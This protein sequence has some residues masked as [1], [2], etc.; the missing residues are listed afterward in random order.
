MQFR[1][2]AQLLLRASLC[3]SPVTQN[4]PC[5]VGW[6]K[7]PARG[8]RRS[9]PVLC[10]ETLR[11]P[12]GQGRSERSPSRTDG[13][14][15]LHSAVPRSSRVENKHT[16]W[17]LRRAT[18]R[19]WYSSAKPTRE[20]DR[21]IRKWFHTVLFIVSPQG[22]H[23]AKRPYIQPPRYRRHSEAPAICRRL[24]RDSRSPT[25]SWKTWC[26][27]REIR[28]QVENANWDLA[29]FARQRMSSQ[30]RSSTNP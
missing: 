17:R 4:L 16:G 28:P 5:S 26:N 7:G 25:E 18:V 12:G 23:Q 22:R 13:L 24:A 6:V 11:Y 10:H 21:S 30:I 2:G 29:G 20:N 3:I 19:R 27:H 9:R 14:R 15:P 1:S 8:L